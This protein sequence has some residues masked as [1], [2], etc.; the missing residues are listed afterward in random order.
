MV[1]VWWLSSSCL[2]A[3][4]WLCGVVQLQWFLYFWCMEAKVL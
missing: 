4:W 3:V 1:A 2:V